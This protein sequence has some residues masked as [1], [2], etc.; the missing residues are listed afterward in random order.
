[1]Y[2]RIGQLR[3][4]GVGWRLSGRTQSQS[5]FNSL[6]S[7]VTTRAIRRGSPSRRSKAQSLHGD[8]GVLERRDDDDDCRTPTHC[9]RCVVALP[10]SDTTGGRRRNDIHTRRRTSPAPA[11]PRPSRS[12]QPTPSSRRTRERFQL[13]VA[14]EGAFLISGTVNGRGHVATLA[15]P[16]DSMLLA[17][18]VPSHVTHALTP[19]SWNTVADSM[20]QAEWV[21]SHG[22]HA[23]CRGRRRA[24]AV[25][26]GALE[27]RLRVRHCKGEGRHK[28]GWSWKVDMTTLASAHNRYLVHN[29]AFKQPNEGMT[30]SGNVEHCRFAAPALPPVQ[31]S[32]PSAF[33]V[34][35]S[36]DN[37]SGGGTRPNP[38][39]Q[40]QALICDSEQL[41][42]RNSY[43]GGFGFTDTISGMTAGCHSLK[44][45]GS[46]QVLSRDDGIGT[47]SKQ[48]RIEKGGWGRDS[49]KTRIS[50]LT[51]EW[52]VGMM[53]EER[54]RNRR[55]SRWGDGGRDVIVLGGQNLCV[56]L[57]FWSYFPPGFES[58]SFSRIGCIHRVPEDSD[59]GT[60]LFRADLRN[61]MGSQWTY[62]FIRNSE[63]LIHFP[64]RTDA[65]VVVLRD[66]EREEA[67]ETGDGCESGI[68][69]RRMREAR[70][71]L[72]SLLW[73]IR[74]F[75]RVHREVINFRIACI[76]S[77][78]PPQT[79]SLLVV[80]I[81]SISLISTA[82]TEWNVETVQRVLETQLLP[83]G[84]S[85]RCPAAV[86]GHDILICHPSCHR[87]ESKPRLVLSRNNNMIDFNTQDILNGELYTTI[88]S[89][90]SLQLPGACYQTNALEAQP[91]ATN[92]KTIEHSIIT[93]LH[94]STPNPGDWWVLEWDRNVGV[95]TNQQIVTRQD[96]SLWSAK[97]GN[98]C[99]TARSSATQRTA[100]EQGLGSVAR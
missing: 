50:G 28:Y 32:W 69:G 27:R 100:H 98:L 44:R 1:M 97:D 70:R 48:E 2:R 41:E 79:I 83:Q 64:K 36:I 55:E 63:V 16:A 18:W 72:S 84:F 88:P 95:T 51:W 20:L 80:A 10:S 61:D 8:G 38:G 45:A 4:F 99:K 60:A 73:I 33:L 42:W 46:G 15:Y 54:R 94:V 92:T 85:F 19:A 47:P 6:E 59:S 35:A 3:V 21:P 71:N 43:D 67:A 11:T 76:T 91:E 39:R 49:R 5:A 24:V 62:H 13:M 66:R 65:K 40:L 31:N 78:A 87:N 12:S 81:N 56:S 96:Y 26:R 30:G 68:Q 17:E 7:H 86:S 74:S 90:G 25:M 22:T 57:I 58:D 82:Q 93:A 52:G 77:H 23:Q 75:S 53:G 89:E 29:V 34:Y 37:Y 9:T 14:I